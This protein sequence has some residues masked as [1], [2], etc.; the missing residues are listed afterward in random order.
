[1]VAIALVVMETTVWVFEQVIS[2]EAPEITYLEK[3]WRKYKVEK[4]VNHDTRLTDCTK[5]THQIDE[6][7]V[8]KVKSRDSL[9]CFLSQFFPDVQKETY[10]LHLQI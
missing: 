4:C 2:H 5:A 1:M 7:E 10:L 8:K 9:D 3:S 6:K